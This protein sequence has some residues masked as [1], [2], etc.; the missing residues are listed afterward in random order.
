MLISLPVV[1]IPR[2]ETVNEAWSISAVRRDSATNSTALLI[3]NWMASTFLV[4]FSGDLTFAGANIK[5]PAS[6]TT[7]SRIPL[8]G[9]TSPASCAAST[10]FI[11][12]RSAART[13]SASNPPL[14][15]P[16]SRN[17]RNGNCANSVIRP[18]PPWRASQWPAPSACANRGPSALAPWR[19]AARTGHRGP[20][21]DSDQALPLVACRQAQ[22][23][24]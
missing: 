8:R 13:S 15:T 24:R 5:H 4:F 10:C 18:P 19:Q 20:I 16:D 2:S 23:P 21:A 9:A 14:P 22:G 7:R 11:N 1:P 12:G 6:V 3:G 17:L